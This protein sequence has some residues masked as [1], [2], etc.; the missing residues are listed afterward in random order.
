MKWQDEINNLIKDVRIDLNALS[1][2]QSEQ[3]L[4]QKLAEQ[5]EKKE[6]ANR[7]LQESSS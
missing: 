6:K 3:V 1:K 2:D 5:R 7:E 4:R